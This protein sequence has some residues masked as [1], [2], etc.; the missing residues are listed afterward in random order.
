M[1]T[2]QQVATIFR[3]EKSMLFYSTRTI[4]QGLSAC[5][6]YNPRSFIVADNI[7]ENG[8]CCC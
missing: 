7:A 3:K 5:V 1:M 6:M 4:P 2:A 8:R